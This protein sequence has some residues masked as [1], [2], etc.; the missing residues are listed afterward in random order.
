MNDTDRD[1]GAEGLHPNLAR[2]NRT[3]GR[4]KRERGAAVWFLIGLA[5]A[6]VAIAYAA[7]LIL[8]AGRGAGL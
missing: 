6:L 1:M 8:E 7:K 2:L 4:L 5:L 3:A